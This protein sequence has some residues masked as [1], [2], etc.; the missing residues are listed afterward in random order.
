MSLKKNLTIVFLVCMILCIISYL[1]QQIILNI[2]GKNHIYILMSLLC[3]TLITFFIVKFVKAPQVMGG[4]VLITCV[5]VLVA[6]I[7][8]RYRK[9]P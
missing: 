8:L 5:L 6:N 7:L 2:Y 3:S 4:S 1:Y 9:I